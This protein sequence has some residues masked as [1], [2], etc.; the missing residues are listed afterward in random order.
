M[1]KL[2]LNLVRSVINYSLQIERVFLQNMDTVFGYVERITFQN[3]ENG[4][5]IAQLQVKGLKTLI[6]IVGSM[7]GL[8]PGETVRCFGSWKQHLIHGKQ[9]AVSECKREAPADL[10]GIKKY[11]GSGLVRGIGS[12]YASRIVEK[13]GENTLHIIDQHPERLL[14]VEGLGKKRVEKIKLCW[15]EQSSIREVMIFLQSYSVSPAF[16]QKIFKMYGVNSIQ[17]VRENPYRLAR[18]V[19]GIGFKTADQIAERLG[20]EKDSPKRIAAGIEFVLSELASE[21]HVCYPLHHFIVDAEK[22]LGSKKEL[23]ESQIQALKQEGRIEIQGVIHSGNTELFIWAR[24]LFTAELGIAREIFRLKKG[25]CRLRSIDTQRAVTWVQETLSITLAVNQKE[26]VSHALIDKFHIITG[27]PGTGKSTITKAILAITGKLTDKI[28][29]AA[30]TGRAAKRMTEIT[31][32]TAFTIHSLLEFDFK[33]SKFRRNQENPLDC[34]LIIIDESSMI[35]TYLMYSLLKAIPSHARVILVGDIYQLPSVGPGNVL[36]DLI[37]SHCVAVTVLNEIFRQ[38]AGSRIITNAHRIN[39][40]ILPEVKNEKESDFFFINAMQPEEVLQQIVSLVAKRLPDRYRLHPFEDIQVLAPMK[41]GIIGIENLNI[42]LQEALNGN[43]PPVV[44][45][46]RKF[47]VGDKV[48][49]IQNNY[50]REVYNGDIGR[51]LS[52]DSTEQQMCVRIDDREVIYGFSDLDEIVLSYAVSIHKYQGSESP[53][54]VIPVHTSHYMLL[55]RNLF[56]TGVT[57]GKKLVILVGTQKA[58]HIAVQNDEVK[59]RYTG[60]QQAMMDCRPVGALI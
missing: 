34:D 5:T 9:F 56:Y 44:I 51:I 35:D 1:T 53:C 43:S 18:E 47:A 42:V 48:M 26:A 33:N 45:S 41:R 57:R 39:Q 55:N 10:I 4:F 6:C 22:I 12:K 8:M 20:I 17:K 15:S 58:L 21:G 25:K 32:R 50:E 11:L 37:R 16:A 23:I 30:P 14:E 27:G 46:G 54:V 19:K 60:L 49:Q 3:A 7:P 28:L 38:A 31:K 29:L 24:S 59:K 36:K 2:F 52:I 13:F 40:G